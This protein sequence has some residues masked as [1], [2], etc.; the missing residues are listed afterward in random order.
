[1][2]LVRIDLRT[3][4]SASYRRSI[5]GAVHRALVETVDVPQADRFQVITEHDSDCLIYDPKFL[6]IDRDDD[7]VF[8]QITFSI[9]RPVEKKQLLYKRI[10]ELLEQNPGIRRQ[11]VVI[12]LTEVDRAN[13][14]FGN[15]EAQ[16]VPK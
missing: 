16:Y 6:D 12:Q 7:V 3:G 14:S 2:P 10:A 1:M 4:K 15:G 11:N 8:I 13:W 9:G 5:A